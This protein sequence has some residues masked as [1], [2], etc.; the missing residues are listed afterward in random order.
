MPF[1]P[2]PNGIRVGVVYNQD[3]EA[4]QNTMWYRDTTSGLIDLNTVAATFFAQWAGNVMPLLHADTSLVFCIA[5]DMSSVSGANGSYFPPTVV[6]GSLGG[7]A[8][9]N[10]VAFVVT[11][12][13]A[14][15]GRSYRGR[16]YIP[17]ISAGILASPNRVQDSW[18]SD[19]GNAVQTA[20]FTNAPTGLQPVVASFRNGG[21]AR[22][23]GVLTDVTFCFPTDN[24]LDSMRRR[25]PGRGR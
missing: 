19:I 21:V 18:M 20:Y 9:A 23:A 8:E 2:T 14:L 13:T 22:P 12:H 1:V 5:Q 16:I 7:V 4:T 6:P 3:G 24:I 11:I 15:R 25:L 10:N 17:G